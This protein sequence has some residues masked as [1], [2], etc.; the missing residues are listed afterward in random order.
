ME[1]VIGS[2]A[3]ADISPRRTVSSAAF[4]LSV[5]VHFKFLPAWWFVFHPRFLWKV[6]P[7]L[8]RLG[9]TFLIT[10]PNLGLLL[11]TYFLYSYLSQLEIGNPRFSRKEDLAWYLIFVG[12]TIMVSLCPLFC[13]PARALA[14]GRLGAS[15]NHPK[16]PSYIC[17]D[18]A[19][20]LQLSRFLEMRKMTPALRPSPSFAIWDWSAVQAWW[21]V[22]WMARVMFCSLGW[23]FELPTFLPCPL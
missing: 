17:P 23:F 14:P 21:N 2:S 15:T 4:L 20:S 6:P 16:H 7:Q 22:L 8:W 18:S 13:L 5:S 9:T 19:L 1:S 11:D 12:G 10:G 3:S